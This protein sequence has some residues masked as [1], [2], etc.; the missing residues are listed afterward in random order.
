MGRISNIL[1][2]DLQQLENKL[3]LEEKSDISSELGGLVNDLTPHRSLNPI[4]VGMFSL[5]ELQT[6]ND[7]DIKNLDEL[8]EGFKTLK[9]QLN[10][11]CED[12][13]YQK[14]VLK[15]LHD[16]FPRSIETLDINTDQIF[17]ERG[18][19]E[20]ELKHL[21]EALEKKAV[22]AERFV[23]LYIKT[24]DKLITENRKLLGENEALR[25]INNS[26]GELETI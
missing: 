14:D 26:K 13:S 18:Y 3:I 6:M 8:N 4:K 12:T 21:V 20:P 5:R 10:F 15:M 24:K 9:S 22:R 7:E 1:E 19:T 2:D 16:K 17:C 25:E 11:F 23:K